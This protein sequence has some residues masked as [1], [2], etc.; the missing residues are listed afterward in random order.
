V[1]DEGGFFALF[2]DFGVAGAEG[3]EALFFGSFG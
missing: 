1:F 3:V 2:A